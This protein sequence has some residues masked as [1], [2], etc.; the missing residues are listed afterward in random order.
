MFI[1]FRVLSTVSY[2]SKQQP[3]IQGNSNSR[4]S[5]RRACT[6]LSDG[7]YGRGLA[8]K[9]SG[10]YSYIVIIPFQIEDKELI[11]IFLKE[12]DLNVW[13]KGN[14]ERRRRK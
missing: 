2:S 12:N 7:R 14:A 5:S 4:D 6:T 8:G 13:L 10:V 3:N 11:N 9:W 1:L